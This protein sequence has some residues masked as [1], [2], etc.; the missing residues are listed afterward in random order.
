MGTERRALNLQGFVY[1]GW[2]DQPPYPGRTDFWGFHTGLHWID[3][4]PKPAA[5][6]FAKAVQSLGA[7]R[8]PKTVKPAKPTKP[9][10]PGK[11]KPKKRRG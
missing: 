2:R 11:K 3:G 10:K 9:A 5:F 6:A 7:M 8:P 1:Y 4:R